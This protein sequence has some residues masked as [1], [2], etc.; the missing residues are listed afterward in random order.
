MVH[1][2]LIVLLG[3]LI[4]PEGYFCDMKDCIISLH[5]EV[6]PLSKAN[7]HFGILKHAHSCT[8]EPH[9]LFF[10][11]NTMH[12]LCFTNKSSL[13]CNHDVHFFLYFRVFSVKNFINLANFLNL[14]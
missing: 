5:C 14:S 11:A 6:C 8:P 4:M 1:C 2:C 9:P 10:I 13:V 7:T 12:C 3:C